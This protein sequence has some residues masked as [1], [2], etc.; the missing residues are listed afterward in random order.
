MRLHRQR[1]LFAVLKAYGVHNPLVGYKQGM[2]PITST[3]LMY[4][5]DEEVNQVPY[6]ASADPPTQLDDV[7][8]L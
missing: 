5:D 8:S 7:H 2:A 3:I 1:S 4:I 6:P